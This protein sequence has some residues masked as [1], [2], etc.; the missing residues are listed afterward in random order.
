MNITLY[1]IAT[2]LDSQDRLL[3]ETE[4]ARDIDFAGFSSISRRVSTFERTDDLTFAIDIYFEQNDTMSDF[5]GK[6]N[7]VKYEGYYAFITSMVE[8]TQDSLRLICSL[9]TLTSYMTKDA[10]DQN[11][12]TFIRRTHLDRFV[13][14]GGNFKFDFDNEDLLIKEDFNIIPRV[15]EDEGYTFFEF[16]GG[17]DLKWLQITTTEG[18]QLTNMNYKAEGNELQGSVAIPNS[19]YYIP[20]TNRV[21]YRDI[22][23]NALQGTGFP[24]LVI[25]ELVN[26]ADIIDVRIVPHLGVLNDLTIRYKTVGLQQT[27]EVL[28]DTTNTTIIT[29]VVPF[30]GVVNADCLLNLI[31][32]DLVQMQNDTPVDYFDHKPTFTAGELVLNNYEPKLFQFTKYI[33]SYM[34]ESRDAFYDLLQNDDLNVKVQRGLNYATERLDV[35]LESGLYFNAKNTGPFLMCISDNTVA[36]NINEWARYTSEK[37]TTSSSMYAYGMPVASGLIGAGVGVATSANRG[38]TAGV[39]G[40]NMALNILQIWAQREDIKQA[41]DK[42]RARGSNVLNDISTPKAFS[43]SVTKA[44]P[45]QAEL[46]IIE[47]YLFQNGYKYEKYDSIYDLID[48]RTVFNYIQTATQDKVLTLG[49]SQAIE[50]DIKDRLNNGVRFYKGLLSLTNKININIERSV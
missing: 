19:T 6:Y 27:I 15:I 34:Q 24:V 44:R 36:V 10:I 18:G 45:L 41:P 33:I 20:L 28:W 7:Y 14:D 46:D 8:K 13:P 40:A 32:G 1:N 43:L 35:F 29:T 2:S 23:T 22:N 11:K 47:S 21:E 3:Y 37:K 49:L 42:S 5:I 4:Q 30:N 25:N 50:K 39:A 9:D 31:T 48:T 17:E 38:L 26:K 12:Q 16:D